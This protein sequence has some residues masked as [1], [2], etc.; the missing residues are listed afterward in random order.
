VE[1]AHQS[2]PEGEDYLRVLSLLRPI[3]QPADDEFKSVCPMRMNR[4][5]SQNRSH[6]RLRCVNQVIA[7]V[8][9]PGE[10]GVCP[11]G[12]QLIQRPMLAKKLMILVCRRA[13]GVIERMLIPMPGR[14]GVI[15]RKV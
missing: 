10:R 6:S 7:L 14:G 9:M 5:H 12:L 4:L 8:L 15:V 3:R 11:G 13:E 1:I 2:L